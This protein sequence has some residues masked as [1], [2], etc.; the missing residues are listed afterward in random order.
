MIIV[1]NNDHGASSP[2]W[3]RLR[4][5]LRRELGAK[6]M[7]VV[8]KAEHVKGLAATQ[9]RGII[10]S[11]GPL[12]LSKPLAFQDIAMNSLVMSMFPQV[13][14]LGICF[15]C[16]YL[17][18][19][20]GTPL[21]HQSSRKR[22]KGRYQVTIDTTHPLFESMG[23]AE[24]TMA[25]FAFQDMI[26]VGGVDYSVWKPLAWLEE[27]N[28]YPCAWAHN[29]RPWYGVMFHPEDVKEHHGILRTF[30]SRVCGQA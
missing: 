16:Q 5:F 23:G 4:S 20:H 27:K 1:V 29:Q 3:K 19:L 8:T 28:E 15:G 21:I 14:V 25:S 10:L 13:P 12:F 6:N 2:R 11:G 22:V 17:H 9:V 24:S 18:A 30:L 26:E 7:C